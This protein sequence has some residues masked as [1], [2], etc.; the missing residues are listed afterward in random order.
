[1]PAAIHVRRIGAQT[2]A[3]AA[4]ER[5]NLII[6]AQMGCVIALHA[7]LKSGDGDDGDKSTKRLLRL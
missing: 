7:L 3:V 6:F 1:M 4:M 2:N 5:S